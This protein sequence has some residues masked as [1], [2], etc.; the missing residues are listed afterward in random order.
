[1]LSTSNEKLSPPTLIEHIAWLSSFLYLTEDNAQSSY[2]FQP[3]C[4]DKAHLKYYQ[5]DGLAT[6]LS[7]AV[8]NLHV[9]FDSA[10]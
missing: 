2:G 9:I 8:E 6:A 5:I 1:M 7:A 10:N 4:R 3:Q